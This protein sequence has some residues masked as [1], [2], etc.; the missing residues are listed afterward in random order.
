[1]FSIIYMMINY[2]GNYL[3]AYKATIR[4]FNISSK[5]PRIIVIDYM[6]VNKSSLA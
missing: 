1:M 4:D 3:P 2:A 5:L 6:N